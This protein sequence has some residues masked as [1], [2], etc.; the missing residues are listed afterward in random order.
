MAVNCLVGPDEGATAET[1]GGKAAALG[2]LS[3]AGFP[4]PA[5][6]AL[7][8]DGFWASLPDDAARAFRD[9]ADWSQARAALD[10]IAI[11]AALATQIQE[12]L[13]SLA[14]A[15]VAVRSS[16][17]DEDSRGHSFAGQLESYLGV[18]PEEVA[19]RIADVWRSAVTER[20]LAYRKEHGLPLTP[21]PPGVLVQAMI[22]ADAA[23]VGFSAD[24]VGGARSVRIVSAVRGLGTALVSGEAEADTWRV[25]REGV[26]LD[27]AIAVKTLEHRMDPA[28]GHSVTARIVS[29]AAASAPALRSEDVIAV[30]R[31]AERA[32]RHFG[33]PQDIEWAVRE[34]KAYL[35]QSRPIT[36][37]GGLADPDGERVIWDN[38][39][40]VESYGGITTPLTFSF[41]RRA[42]EEVYRE[43]CRLMG[44]P[45]GRV[46]RN[47]RTFRAMLGLI[48]GRVYYNLTNWYRVLALLPGFQANRRFMEQMMGVKEPLPESVA[49]ELAGAGRLQ[50][51]GD[52]MLLMR[53]LGGLVL[54]H[55]TLE[56]RIRAFY[57]RLESA[58]AEPP[59]SLAAMRLD[60]L[61]I[62]YRDLERRLLAWWDAPLVNDFFAMIFYGALRKLAQ[63]WCGD[64]GGTLQNDLLCGEG[65]MISAE[66]AQRV[67]N[68][69][70]L[71]A[72]DPA[73]VAL[74]AA[75]APDVV[76][77]RLDAYP[78][79]RTEL[80]A[81]IAK[82]GDRCLEELKL[83]SASLRDDPTTLL[84]AIA[85]FAQRAEQGRSDDGGPS[86]ERRLR[87][88]AE[89]RVA[90][91]LTKNPA[92]RAIFRWVLRHARDR[93]RDRENLRFERTRL[94]GRCRAIFVE[95]GKR[96]YALGR[97]DDPRDVFYLETEEALGFVE[98]TAT[99]TDLAS[100]ARIRKTEFARYP[101]M[102][103]PAERFE[104]TGA[105]HQGNAFRASRP[106]TE[107]PAGDHL[108]GTG[109]CPGAVRGRARV[110]H[111][112]RTAR[113]EQGEI[114]VARY[115]DPGWIM[116]FPACAG[117]LVERGSM[118]SHSAIVAREM[119]IP[120][121]VGL[122]GVTSWV[123]TG[124]LV[125]MDGASGIV[126]IVERQAA[127]AQSAAV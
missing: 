35:L 41:A 127:K 6:F 91:A 88:D 96:L 7:T 39:N 67:R 36:T 92:K 14:A 9:A 18:A 117:L 118:L 45:R 1:I 68:L 30:A 4:I 126:R 43:F 80:D 74:L 20:V 82:F 31:L 65:G 72:R 121:I 104:T 101:A 23:G 114:L 122:A 119:A 38:S 76:R 51:L 11:P 84:R 47:R 69:A 48:R 112:P 111:D 94:F 52:A 13:K 120:A 77:A 73:L 116:L 42:Y 10:A 2:R 107:A 115:T 86:I 12:R 113:I 124:D 49:A 25:S 16:A 125:D 55:I 40:I 33:V 78:E 90:T 108:V 15:R 29:G 59:E 89:S 50:R 60:E 19:A 66:P 102:D 105:V 81:Y 64:A 46:E 123:E 63:R 106:A 57:R 17:I 85:S 97:L 44:V 53:T 24:P 5:W 26:I 110:I 27:C 54:N 95:I 8:P 99:A 37:L 21:H 61:V 79:F 22:E 98:A 28:A 83:E 75:A 100:M 32:E 70:G 109:A 93:V 71:A 56:R 34:G 62:H 58:L 103:A 3:R 87:A